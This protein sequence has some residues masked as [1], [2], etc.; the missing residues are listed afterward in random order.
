MHEKYSSGTNAPLGGACCRFDGYFKVKP[1][2]EG[3]WTFQGRFDDQIA[4]TV[5]YDI[6]NLQAYGGISEYKGETAKDY[7]GRTVPKHAYGSENLDRFTSSAKK[8]TESLLAVFERIADPAL[9]IRRLT[10]AAY[11]VKMESTSGEPQTVQLNLFEDV[12][13]TEKELEK[14]RKHQRAVLEIRKKYGNNV[15]L[16]GTDLYGRATAKERNMQ[17]GG[18]KAE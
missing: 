12:E 8:V 6:S 11:H 17:V 4:L 9:L 15:L 10:V 5:N 13:Q 16:K 14:E 7:Y 1:E 2:Q 18:H 3:L